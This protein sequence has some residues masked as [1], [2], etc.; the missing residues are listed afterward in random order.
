M[1]PV[2]ASAKERKTIGAFVS[3]VGRAWSLDFMAGITAAAEEHD[4]NL[5]CFVGG[6]PTPILTPGHIQASYG[7]YD[8]ARTE[9]LAGIVVSSD[10]GY[11]IS[12]IEAKQFVDNYSRI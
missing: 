9:Q 7:L 10:L 5:I 6:K 12:A 8:L 1:A 2:K 11:D 3:R 4:L